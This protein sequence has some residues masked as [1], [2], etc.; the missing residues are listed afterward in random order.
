MATAA[1]RIVIQDD[2][3]PPEEHEGGPPTAPPPQGPPRAP[4]RGVEESSTA[5]AKLVHTVQLIKRWTAHSEHDSEEV[6]E[7]FLTRFKPGGPNIDDAYVNNAPQEREGEKGDK[8]SSPRIKLSRLVYF[9]PMG[10]ALYYWLAVV[11]LAVLYNAFV[12]IAR[13]TFSALQGLPWQLGIW[14]LFDYLAD[15]VY[16]LD[17]VVQFRTGWAPPPPP[18]PPPLP[19]PPPSSSSSSPPPPPPSFI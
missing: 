15:V 13:Q 6:R 18:P 7:A 19:P 16:V 12:V 17:M 2:T 5:F 11:T 9:N 4:R 1:P 14:L 10:N 3:P 8:P